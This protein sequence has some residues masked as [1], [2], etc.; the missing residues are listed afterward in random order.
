MRWQPV[1][2]MRKRE[3]RKWKECSSTQQQ[4]KK[5]THKNEQE[6]IEMT[7]KQFEELCKAVYPH[8]KAIQEALKGN[9]EE[10]SASISVGSD[11]YLNF[12][13][14]NSDWELSK[15]KDSQATMKYE[16]R[17]ILKME[18]DE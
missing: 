5:G 8:L 16:H 14:Y 2:W 6:K 10:M 7:E 3:Q 9:G 17:T 1:S 13:P 15:F 11:G 12:H 4:N 18:E